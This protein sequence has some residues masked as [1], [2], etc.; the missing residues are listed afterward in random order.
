[1]DDMAITSSDGTGFD[2][3]K[4]YQLNRPTFLALGQS[5]SFSTA[6]AFL[7]GIL[8]F[9]SFFGDLGFGSDDPDSPWTLT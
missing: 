6:A 3:Q 9:D 4:V 5:F 7:I 8:L 2:I 1:M